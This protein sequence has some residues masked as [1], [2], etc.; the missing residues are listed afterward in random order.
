MHA[1]PFVH[2]SV[3]LHIVSAVMLLLITAVAAG[4]SSQQAVRSAVAAFVSLLSR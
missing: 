3:S 2:G 1:P 4:T